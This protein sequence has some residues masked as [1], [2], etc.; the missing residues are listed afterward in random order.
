MT[1]FHVFY[2]PVGWYLILLPSGD[3][4]LTPEGD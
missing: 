4:T 2:G 3:L 1:L